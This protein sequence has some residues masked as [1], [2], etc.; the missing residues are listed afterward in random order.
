MPF[1]PRKYA[2][3]AYKKVY[4]SR[5][6]SG[7]VKKTTDVAKDVAALTGSVAMIMSRLNVEKNYKDTAIVQ[8][9]FGQVN[10]NADGAHISDITP[11]ISQGDGEGNRHGNSLKM[12]GFSIPIQINGM[13]ACQGARKIR[14]SLLKVKS[15]DNG[16]STTEAFQHYWDENPLTTMRDYNCP[17]NYRSGAHDGITCVRSSTYYL[18]G[19]TV[20]TGTVDAEVGILTTKF[21]VKLNDVLRYDANSDVLPLGVKYYLVF[22]A[23]SGNMSA[24]TSGIGVPVTE[25]NSGMEL[26]VGARAWYV[27][28]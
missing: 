3:K 14:I 9:T 20:L 4:G 24:S 17:R 5:K 6:F 16:V 21:N 11:S 2:K 19:P 27:D 12:T 8:T 28:N 22:Q 18:K 10:L 26:R 15:A 13:S 1:T 23:D 7:A 25:G